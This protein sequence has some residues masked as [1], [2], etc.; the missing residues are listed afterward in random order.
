MR[1]AP[2]VLLAFGLLLRAQT[3]L[4]TVTGLASDPSGAAVPGVNITLTSQDTGVKRTTST[5]GA[6]LYSF[7]DLPPGTYRLNADAKSFRPMETRAFAV[8]AFRTVRQDLPLALATA[9]SEVLVTEA[10][11]PMIQVDSPAIATDL[12]SREIVELPTT[13]RSV[14]KNSGDSGLISEIMP[15]TV[16]GVVQVGAGAKWL[17]PGGTAR[18]L[19]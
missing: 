18:R 9:N 19:T 17:T 4:G 8:E 6:G 10:A 1:S 13:L 15:A 2:I 16:P 7:P 11:S 3:P 14:A 12:G 5:N